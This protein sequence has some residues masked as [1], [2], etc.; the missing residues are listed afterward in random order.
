ME[1]KTN[2]TGLKVALNKKGERVRS[3]KIGRMILKIGVYMQILLV[4]YTFSSKIETK[5]IF[6]FEVNPFDWLYYI[7]LAGIIMQM[8]IS[9]LENLSALGYN[10][11]KGLHG[12]ILRKFNKWF[13]FD[14][15]K[16]GDSIQ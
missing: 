1:N 6:G 2:N 13:E 11:A 12:I 14:G 8:V 4:L 9:W 15:T 16:D 5:T 10:E 7:V 3:R